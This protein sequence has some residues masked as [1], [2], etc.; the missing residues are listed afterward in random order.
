MDEIRSAAWLLIIAVNRR[1]DVRVISRVEALRGMKLLM[2]VRV[3]VWVRG[4]VCVRGGL[5][6][7]VP[8]AR[9]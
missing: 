6:W 2:R 5:T 8:A 7:H 3:G 1:F 9:Q 4:A